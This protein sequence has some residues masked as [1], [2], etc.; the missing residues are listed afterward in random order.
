MNYVFDI[1]GTLCTNSQGDY[2]AAKPIYELIKIVNELFDQ[3][4]RIIL[5]TARGMGSSGNNQEIAKAKWE[6]FTKD[7]L[8][9]WGVRYHMLFLGKPSGDLYV[10]DKGVNDSD[11][12]ESVKSKGFV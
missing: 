5:L 4:N 9:S 2:S 11:F 12:F 7:Q 3:G 1:D 8:A 10:D 6:S